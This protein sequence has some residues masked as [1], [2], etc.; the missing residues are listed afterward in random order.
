MVNHSNSILRLD[1]LIIKVINKIKM[2]KG[3]YQNLQ[4][5]VLRSQ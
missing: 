4:S 3:L 5:D 1:E 2:E